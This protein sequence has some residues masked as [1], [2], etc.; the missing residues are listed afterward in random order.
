MLG[1]CCHIIDP[2]AIQFP[3]TVYQEERKKNVS[4]LGGTEIHLQ[5]QDASNEALRNTIE[6]P[7]FLWWCSKGEG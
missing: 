5:F 4:K 1:D 7:E 3:L 2:A 6:D